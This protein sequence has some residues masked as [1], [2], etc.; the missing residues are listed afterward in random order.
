MGREAPS[1]Y[2]AACLVHPYQMYIK[3]TISDMNLCIIYVWIIIVADTNA[4]DG[5]CKVNRLTW[6]VPFRSSAYSKRKID[7]YKMRFSTNSFVVVLPPSSPSPLPPSLPPSTSPIQNKTREPNDPN[8][9]TVRLNRPAKPIPYL[10][11]IYEKT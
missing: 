10:Y 4:V 8:D 5:V 3:H 6:C 2:L 7:G 9:S 11:S 1:S